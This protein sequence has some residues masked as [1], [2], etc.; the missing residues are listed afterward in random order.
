MK[1]K[2]F[3]EVSNV[4]P[5]ITLI[6]IYQR[7]LTGL[8]SQDDRLLYHNAQYFVCLA[9]QLSFNILGDLTIHWSDSH[10]KIIYN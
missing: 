2:H 8:H 5:T 3:I 6:D 10:N 4:C 7:S 1:H 9:L